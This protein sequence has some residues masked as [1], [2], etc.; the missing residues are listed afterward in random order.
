M[1]R[2][3]SKQAVLRA[4]GVKA[5]ISEGTMRR[6]RFL[7]TAQLEETVHHFF[8]DMLVKQLHS[9]F[10]GRGDSSSVIFCGSFHACATYLK[11]SIN[12]PISCPLPDFSSVEHY[13]DGIETY[14]VWLPLATNSSLAF[15][16]L[17][18]VYASVLPNLSHVASARMRSPTLPPEER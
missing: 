9:P 1:I 14:F 5:S 12:Q 13:K 2:S 10:A 6:I 11:K 17:I 18:E 3:L 15:M 7:A 16:N 8:E 4:I